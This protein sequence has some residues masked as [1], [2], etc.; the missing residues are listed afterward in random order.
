MS[1]RARS[2][3]TSRN[4]N[5]VEHGARPYLA[6]DG[7]VTPSSTAMRP[8]AH[9]QLIVS[10]APPG[11]EE[12]PRDRISTVQPISSLRLR[13]QWLRYHAPVV[14]LW[15]ASAALLSVAGLVALGWL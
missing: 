3:S 14:A 7:A 12:E 15:S 10:A 2:K 6:R 4:C 9:L 11:T 1:W 13:L 5:K 8:R